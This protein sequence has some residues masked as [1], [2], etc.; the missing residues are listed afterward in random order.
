LSLK[1]GQSAGVM[2]TPKKLGC[3]RQKTTRS[4][5]RFWGHGGGREAPLP[6]HHA[7][8]RREGSLGFVCVHSPAVRQ[9][10]ESWCFEAM[11]RCSGLRASGRVRAKGAGDGTEPSIT[12]ETSHVSPGAPRK[13]TATHCHCATRPPPARR[14][15]ATHQAGP[16][17][18]DVR[19]RPDHRTAQGI[20]F[21]SCILVARGQE[22]VRQTKNRVAAAQDRCRCRCRPSP[23]PRHELLRRPATRAGGGGRHGARG[24]APGWATGQHAPQSGSPRRRRRRGSRAPRFEAAWAPAPHPVPVCPGAAD[25]L[26]AATREH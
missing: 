3:Q 24:R 14:P 2:T 12:S 23:Q 1:D 18:A 17:P 26:V 19:L 9:K 15:S 10:H 21:V 8:G 6:T 20:A 16:V 4:T 13:N 7:T 25:C 22:R 5:G 11:A